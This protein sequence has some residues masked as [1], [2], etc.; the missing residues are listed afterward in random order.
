M[1]GGFYKLFNQEKTII[2]M[3]HLAGRDQKER[4]DRA[5]EEVR[6]YLE[7]GVH[8]FIVEDYH[9]DLG[10]VTAVL[11]IFSRDPTIPMGVNILRDPYLAFDLADDYG[12]S[13][14]QFDTIQASPGSPRNNRRF[15]E[16]KYLERRDRYPEI[17]VLGGVRFKYIPLTGRSLEED[18]IEGISR[19]EAIVTTGSGTGIETPTEKLRMFKRIMGDF[20]LVVGAGVNDKNVREQLEVA[21]A[22]IIGSYFKGGNTSD[23]VSRGLV[24]KFVALSGIR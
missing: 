24:K 17:V 22:A 3:I 1:L 7:E 12:A 21:E 11:E 15:N 16:E 2:G 14:V 10:D 6:I 13:F 9:G 23:R 8:G 20:P 18:I 4:I 19:C 5:V